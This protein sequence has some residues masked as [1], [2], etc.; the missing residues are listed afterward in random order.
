MIVCDRNRT[1]GQDRRVGQAQRSPTVGKKQVV[2]GR[3]HIGPLV[4]ALLAMALPPATAQEKFDPAARAKVVAPLIDEQTVAVL[5]VD[6]SRMPVDAMLAKA[7]GILPGLEH[8]L[9]RAR[10]DVNLWLKELAPIAGKE[11]YVVVSTADMGG[12]WFWYAPRITL[13]SLKPGVDEKAIA[14]ALD[15]PDVAKKRIGDF[16]LIAPP[17]TMKRLEALKAEPRPAL[18]AAFEAAGDT[19]AQVLLFVPPYARRAIEE[20]MPELPKE[21]GGGPSTLVTHGVRWIAIGADVAPQLSARLVI[22]SQDA[23]AAEAL[24]NKWVEGFK[25]VGQYKEVRQFV[26]QFD[27]LAALLTPKLEGDRISIALDT[28]AVGKV[29]HALEG[30][31][32]A[33]REDYQ[34]RHAMNQLK[35]IGLAMLNYEHEHKGFPPRATSGPDGKPLLSWRVLILPYLDRQVYEQFHLNEPWD[36][37]HNRTLIDKMPEVYRLPFSKLKDPGKT[38]YVV[39]VGPGTV[40]GGKERMKLSDIKD[41]TSRTIMVVEADDQ[42]AVVWSKPDDLP[43]DPKEPL[44]GLG[45]HMKDGFMA[46]LCDNSV[47]FF[48]LTMKPDSLRAFFSAAAGDSPGW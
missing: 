2:G 40:F 41:G 19:G 13:V 3:W 38:N 22:Q 46:V 32:A 28:Q 18:T 6:T 42:H 39:P 34:R 31:I 5:H 11:L 43:Y 1:V 23:Q 36:S 35:H 29:L 25:R 37:P 27:Q 48:P 9:G 16:L 7:W 15:A 30:P 17:K 21:I 24:R 47:H 12:S 14:K 33:A 4:L 45:G 44:R 20:L 8:E 26:P 10:K